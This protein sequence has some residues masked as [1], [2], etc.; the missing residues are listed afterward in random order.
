MLY[1]EAMEHTKKL[2]EAWKN[3]I[4]ACLLAVQISETI[5]MNKRINDIKYVRLHR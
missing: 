1:F 3:G 4:V 2:N 5:I